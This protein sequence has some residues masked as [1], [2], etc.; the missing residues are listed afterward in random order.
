MAGSGGM[1]GSAGMGGAAGMGGMGGSGGGITCVPG[2]GKACYSGAPGTEN[3]G[4]CKGGATLCQ[5]DGMSYGECLGEV[6][7]VIEEC[8]TAAADDDCNGQVNDHC[9]IWATRAGTALEQGIW[10]VAADSAG[11]VL[12]TGRMQ[13]TADFGGGVLTS[14]GGFD[15]FV[16]KFD[17]DGKHLWSKIFGGMTDDGGYGIAVNAK[18][19]SFVTGFFTGSM[20]IGAAGVTAVDGQDAFIIK[21][22]S[23]GQVLGYAI[24]DGLTDQRGNAIAVDSAGDVLVTGTFATELNT[25]VGKLMSSNLLDGFVV[26]LNTDLVAQWQKAFGGTGD[27]EGTSVTT[28][29]ANRVYLT[30]Y[31]DETVDFGGGVIGDGGSDDFFLAKLDAAGAHILSKGFPASGNQYGDS[32]AVDSAGNMFI[33][34]EFDTEIDLGAGLV[35]AVGGFDGY[36][37]KFDAMGTLVWSKTYGDPGQQYGRAMTVD[38]MGNVVGTFG[39][40]GAVDYGGGIITNAGAVGSSDVIVVKLKGSTG[41]HIWSRRFGNVSDQDSRCVATDSNNN[42]FVGGD[43]YGSINV[44]PVTIT[45]NSAR[46]AFLFK[47]PP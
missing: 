19:D 16:A 17:P 3:V 5:A 35:T 8:G 1:G 25:F 4:V 40:E 45:A 26:K 23:A 47:M 46:D 31:F 21:L 34:G 2:T 38:K 28:D 36:I 37:A 32:I 42:I 7:P 41:D 18:G 15:I 6:V 43:F 13:G 33:L 44:G 30:G 9:G 14:A 39:H 11:N 12:V 22:D 24:F 20:S 29:S 27:D 10:A